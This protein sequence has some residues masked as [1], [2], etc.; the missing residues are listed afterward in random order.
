M[1]LNLTPKKK[2]KKAPLHPIFALQGF[3][4]YPIA[5]STL[6][7]I[8]GIFAII[9]QEVIIGLSLLGGG[10][11]MFFFSK[12]GLLIS[13]IVYFYCEEKNRPTD[14]QGD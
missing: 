3:L 10:L 2:K 1:N 11:T 14:E 13:D 12:L 6:F 7:I 9:G 8:I 5:L 4:Y